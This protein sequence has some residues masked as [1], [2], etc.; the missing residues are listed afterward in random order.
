MKICENKDD[1][2]KEQHWAI[3]QFSDFFKD[4]TTYIAFNLESEWIEEVEN[5]MNRCNGHNHNFVALKVVPSKIKITY[6]VET[7]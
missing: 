3:I 7:F 1:V 2:P 4:T 6:S 5:R